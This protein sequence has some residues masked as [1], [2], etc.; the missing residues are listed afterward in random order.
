MKHRKTL[1]ISIW[2]IAIGIILWFSGSIVAGFGIIYHVGR[3][4][5]SGWYELTGAYYLGV[6]LVWSGII[7]ILVGAFG[8]VTTGIKE[9]LDREKKEVIEK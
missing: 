1:L 3:W 9:Y 8:L 7:S 2:L 5:T 6:G 4:F